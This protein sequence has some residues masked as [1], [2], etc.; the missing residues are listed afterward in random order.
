MAIAIMVFSEYNK[1]KKGKGMKTEYN[2]NKK[3]Q[4]YGYRFV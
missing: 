4:K 2:K 1:K 3:I